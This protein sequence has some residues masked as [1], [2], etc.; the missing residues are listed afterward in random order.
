MVLVFIILFVIIMII[1]LS[2]LR[3]KIDNLELSNIRGN[4]NS[5]NKFKIIISLYLFN[6][7][8]W[9]NIKIG[10]KKLKNMYKKFNLKNLEKDF[11]FED[12]KQ[13]KKLNAKFS[14]F[15][16]DS[17]IGLE[18]VIITIFSVVILSTIISL[19]LADMVKKYKK[20]KYNY[21]ILPLYINKNVY[22][23]KFNCI[24]EVKMVH[25]ISII[26]YFLKKRRD[27]NYGKRT[28]NRGSYDYS[29]E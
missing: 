23:I 3:I 26:Y 8:K 25:I 12:L 22:E 14:Y 29:Y 18:N 1:I 10:N 7:I 24:I 16:L 15:D 4:N 11:K 5:S 17:K 9:F 2:T 13:I 27:K 6:K 19:I 20:N 21:K 28:S